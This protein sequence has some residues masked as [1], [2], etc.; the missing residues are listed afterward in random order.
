M[1]KSVLEGAGR[2]SRK[3]SDGGDKGLTSYEE[4]KGSPF[5]DV[6]FVGAITDRVRCTGSA[7]V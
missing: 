2:E 7:V 6:T 4:G 3:G 5:F 1:L